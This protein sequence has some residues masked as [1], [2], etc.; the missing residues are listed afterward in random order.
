MNS[1]GI[2]ML[3][4]VRLA[5]SFDPGRILMTQGA[6]EELHQDDVF[7]CF[8]RHLACDWGNLDNHDREENDFALKHGLRL[9]SSYVDRRETKFWIITE[10][11]RSATTILLPKEY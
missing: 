1:G 2:V 6:A 11:D 7:K 8:V 5:G 4:P 3:K 9:F 10:A